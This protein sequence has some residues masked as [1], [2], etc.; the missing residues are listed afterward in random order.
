MNPNTPIV[1]PPTLQLSNYPGITTAAFIVVFTG[2]LLVISKR[3]DGTGGSLTVSLIVL[4][5]FIAML[6]YVMLYTVPTDEIT[7]AAAGGLV[8]AFGAVIAFWLGRARE[9]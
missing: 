5:M 1:A 6:V 2:V 3:F 8:A 9:K 7:S 4:G